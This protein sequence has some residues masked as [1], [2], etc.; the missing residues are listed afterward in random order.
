MQIELYVYISLLFTILSPS[1]YD[2]LLILLES[3]SKLAA[4]YSIQ[5]SY[6]CN[7]YLLKFHKIN[8]LLIPG[9]QTL[10]NTFY[11]HIKY[12]SIVYKYNLVVMY[13]VY[14]FD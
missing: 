13:V 9:Y 5:V 3:M 8:F 11:F 6:W 4:I 1:H 14:N 7:F 12:Y 10:I 2:K